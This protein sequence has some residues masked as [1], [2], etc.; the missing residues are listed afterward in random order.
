VLLAEQGA[1]LMRSMTDAT[2]A[3]GFGTTPTDGAVTAGAHLL[4]VRP[5]PGHAGIV[6][7]LVLSGSTNL[8]LAKLQLE[9][10]VPPH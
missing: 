5:V 10:I 9:R 4:L 7:H 1:K 2:R 6:V 3:L 8:T